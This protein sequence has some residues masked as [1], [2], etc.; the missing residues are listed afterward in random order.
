M[1]DEGGKLEKRRRKGVRGVEKEGEESNWGGE[2]GQRRQG[3]KEC[4]NVRCDPS[5]DIYLFDGYLKGE[6]SMISHE[7]KCG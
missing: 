1:R 5:I 3:R 4:S 2:E 6:L 7:K